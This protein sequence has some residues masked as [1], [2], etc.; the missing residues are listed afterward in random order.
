MRLTRLFFV[1][2]VLLFA[3]SVINAQDR[4]CGTDHYHAEQMQDERYAER[5]KRQSKEVIN[6]AAAQ[7]G[8][9]DDCTTIVTIP[10]AVHFSGG[11]TDD[12]M[13][14]LIDV[15]L[16][17]IDVLNEDF[18]ATNA[19]ISY[20]ND[21]TADCPD[22]YP[23][24][25]LNGGSCIEFCMAKVNHPAGTG[26]TEG[27]YAITVG[28]HSWPSA[29]STWADYMNIFV[30]DNTGGLGVAP[31]FGANNP[32][33][34][35]FQVDASAFGGP[36]VSC[37]S[38]VTIN[39]S[40]I[41]NL[42]RTGT[43]EAGHYFGIR[44]VFD[45]CS[46]GD[47]IDDT[48]NQSEPNYGSPDVNLS[49]CTSDA[50]NTC[51]EDDYFF[52]YMDYVNDASMIMF[53]TDQAD[54]MF[55]TA[56]QDQWALDKCDAVVPVA[57]FTPTSDQ[58]LCDG[59]EFTFNDTSTGAPT[60]WTWTIT[61][62]DVTV[63]NDT[64]ASLTVIFNT[65]GTYTTTL[66]VSNTAGSD[67][68]TDSSVITVL[69]SSDPA[70]D[71]CDYELVM[72]DRRENGWSTGQS[73]DVD[74]NGTTTNYTGPP[75]G[76]LSIT[77][78]LSL[79]NNDIITITVNTGTQSID[80]MS[81]RV[82]DEEG[83]VVAGSGDTFG[84][85]PGNA[86]SA[87]APTLDSVV[88]GESQTFTTDC[89]S[90]GACIDYTL[91]ITLDNFPDET[92]WQI[93][94]EDGDYV[95]QSLGYDDLTGT[96]TESLCLPAGCYDLLFIDY[97]GD[98]ICCGE[99]A[100]SYE[101]KRDSDNFIAASGG[102]FDGTDLTAFCSDDGLCVDDFTTD[103]SIGSGDYVGDLTLTSTGIVEPDSDVAFYGGQTVSLNAGF[104]T[105][106]ST[107]FFADNENCTTY[108]AAQSD[109]DT[110]NRMVVSNPHVDHVIITQN[111]EEIY[112]SDR[113]N[114]AYFD[115]DGSM[116]LY[117]PTT[118]AADTI[119]TEYSSDGAVVTQYEMQ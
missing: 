38:G 79:T 33:G 73:L 86:Q 14:C 25:A 21:L 32:N 95:Y 7:S 88:D 100:G 53:T 1:P 66:T 108:N 94:D 50:D 46:N 37:T 55:S 22:L 97:Y 89:S 103:A 9:N 57:S 61:G 68:F 29:G 39:G 105:P 85:G 93:L 47:Q 107:D 114:A 17:Q 34:N 92:A 35:G 43:H 96:I 71:V 84:I 81:Y 56:D 18:A 10:V 118:D 112:H 4:T 115:A 49:D 78:I 27:D 99:G 6:R 28:E 80:Q 41:Y 36:G 113:D 58:T 74:I 119:V 26:I 31:L 40:N 90:V 15:C 63:I 69:A 60:S 59:T 83:Y 111:G 8:R 19:D 23:A 2:I 42:G 110:T 91:S 70:C 64:G 106:S 75:S 67:T 45:G 3:I 12:D 77:E 98:G 72:W 62:P 24:S 102:D 54:L 5:F 117:P 51:S 116:I 101:L 76:D 65:T 52:N 87:S 13:Q 16:A 20:Y 44:H 82:F 48:P 30:E 11:I 109:T 104:E